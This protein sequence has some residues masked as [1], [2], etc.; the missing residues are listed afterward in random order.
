MLQSMTG[1]ST[2]AVTLTGQQGDVCHVTMSLK[3]LNSRFFETTCKLPQPFSYLETDIIRLFKKKLRRGHLYFIV[4]ASNLDIF[5][6]EIKPCLTTVRAYVKAIEEIRSTV[7]IQVPISLDHILRLPDIFSTQ[8]AQMNKEMEKL[9]MTGIDELIAALMV[10]RNREGAYL[11]ED[12]QGR[13]GMLEDLI[14]LVMERSSIAIGI[15]K[16]KAQEAIDILETEPSSLVESQKIA[17]YMALDKMDIQEEITRFE[18]HLKNLRMHLFNTKDEEKGKRI[19][20]ILQELN[21]EVN[22][23]GAKCSDSEISAHAINI[24]VEIEK[25]REQIQNIV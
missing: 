3:S 22:T 10:E 13:I 24:K 25:I 9:F 12:M 23:I 16:K 4:H 11:A 21:R 2:K 6:G 1:F 19:D 20:F 7:N 15:Q 18:G 8:I 14:K 5:Q 17:H